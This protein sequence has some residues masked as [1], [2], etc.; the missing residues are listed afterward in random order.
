MF[1]VVVRRTK[2]SL[3]LLLLGLIFTSSAWAQ[4]SQAGFRTACVSGFADG[5][6]CDAVDL[7]AFIPNSTLGPGARE[8]L[9]LWGWT[10][11]E[12]GVEYVLAGM[13]DRTSFVDI[14]DPQSPRVVGHLP[15]SGAAAS[16]WRDVKVY[17]N[18]AYIVAD[19]SGNHGLQVF[20]LTQLRSAPEGTEFQMTAHYTGFGSAHNVAINED[21]GFAYVVGASGG[22]AC[23]GGLHMINIQIPDTPRFVGCFSHDGTGRSGTGYTHDVQC[24]QYDGPDL[25]YAGKEICLGANETAVSIV[26]VTVKGQPRTVAKAEYPGVAYAHQGWLTE[27]Q[28]IFLLGDELDERAGEP[29]RSLIFDVEDLDDPV[30]LGEYQAVTRS[31]DH[32]MYVKGDFV[33]QANYTSGLRILDISA[34]ETPVEIAF[35][36]T[37]PSLGG[38]QFAGSWSTYPYFESGTIAV[39]SIGEGLFL[40]E[41]THPS[42]SVGTQQAAGIP[43][44]FSVTAA[45]PNPFSG[46]VTLELAVE[47]AGSLRVTVLDLLGRELSVLREGAVQP[48]SETIRFDGSGLAPGVYMVRMDLDGVTITRPITRQ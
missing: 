9:D 20:D 11:P 28:R 23:G 33:Y 25:D 48:G 44:T 38:A 13:D 34:P 16:N 42:L 47:N 37:T 15:H 10:D 31:I 27:D 2:D 26:D 3:A 29:A 45:W 8:S 21:T 1:S 30:Y 12:T 32:N 5:Y 39:S 41:P 14:S 17:A 36:D 46:P 18:H 24:V 19:R 6:P 4:E 40:L 7:L 43:G 35:F 22:Q